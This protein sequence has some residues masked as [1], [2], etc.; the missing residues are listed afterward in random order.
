V[1]KHRKKSKDQDRHARER[2]K[3][4]FGVSLDTNLLVS[5]IQKNQ[6][7][8][9]CRQSLRL[10]VYRYE[11]AGQDAAVV[12]DKQRK[13]IVTVMPY[14]WTLSDDFQNTRE[15]SPKCSSR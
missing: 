3:E 11:I 9:I 13:T 14:E 2:C 6:L 4:R 7:S 1:K 12:Y 10:T 15:A 8:V 5:K